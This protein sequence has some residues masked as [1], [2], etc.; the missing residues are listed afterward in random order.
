MK[1][2]STRPGAN[3]SGT[4]LSSHATGTPSRSRTRRSRKTGE[5]GAILN[6]SDSSRLAG[7]LPAWSTRAPALSPR[8]RAV[9]VKDLE[10]V[11]RL[12]EHAGR[13]EP[14]APRRGLQHAFLDEDRQR[15][16]ERD[17]AHPE[18]GAQRALGRKLGAAG[19]PPARRLFGDESG[20]LQIE[21]SDVRGV[22]GG[23]RG[24][25]WRQRIRPP[26]IPVKTTGL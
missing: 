3:A 17:A 4:R 12:A 24:I 10:R 9:S 23:E 6:E 25:H 8:I 19:E 5:P 16:A 18:L 26:W 21:R 20:N 2:A 11:R 14:P 22:D 1:S 7:S 15:P 13:D